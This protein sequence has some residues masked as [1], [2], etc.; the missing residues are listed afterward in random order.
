MIFAVSSFCQNTKKLIQHEF[1][2]S[3]FKYTISQSEGSTFSSY[4]LLK[5]YCWI[6][7]LSKNA[8]FIT[9]HKNCHKFNI[10]HSA[11]E[12]SQTQYFPYGTPTV[13]DA[14]FLPKHRN[15]E[16]CNIL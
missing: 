4:P 12:R 5:L 15:C 7:K 8:T 16:K 10:F 1:F 6:H 14:K 2:A 3:R 9:Q 11:Y 13:S